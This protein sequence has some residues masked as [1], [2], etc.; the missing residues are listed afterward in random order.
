MPDVVGCSATNFYIPQQMGDGL[1]MVPGAATLAEEP[2]IDLLKKDLF[3]IF[4]FVFS[5]KEPQRF[6]GAGHH[7]RARPM[8]TYHND[9]RNPA[10]RSHSSSLGP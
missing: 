2:V 6:E 7:P 3:V 10:A 4:V 9:R 8:H 1:G 5:N